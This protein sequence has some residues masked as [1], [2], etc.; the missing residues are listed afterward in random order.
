MDKKFFK[1]LVADDDEIPRDIVS[2][3]LCKE[4][5][6]VVSATNGIEAIN[7]LR[8]EDINLVI[9]DLRMP[10]ADGLDVL[11]HA[12]II[13]PEAAVVIL[14]AYGTLD[15]ALGAIKGGA[16]DYLTK[17]FKVQEIL[18][19]AERAYKRVELINENRELIKHLR[20]IYGD[21]EV[22]KT[23]S[24]SNNPLI[25]TGWIERIERLK[26]MNILSAQESEKLKKRLIRGNGNGN[27]KGKG[28]EKRGGK[29]IDS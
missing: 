17:P 3:I 20:D 28:K 26:E 15:T 13:N 1:I 7:I 8:L 18:I 25:I 24:G 14:T 6:S 27:G 5:Y 29:S 16:Y 19:L 22:I 4:G 12:L 21:I 23:V 10:G 11:K 9:T 2:S